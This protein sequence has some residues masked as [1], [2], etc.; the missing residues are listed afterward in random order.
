MFDIRAVR[1]APET[2]D[3]IWYYVAHHSMVEVLR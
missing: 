3:L 1:D 2:F